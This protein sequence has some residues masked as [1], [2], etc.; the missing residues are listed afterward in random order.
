MDTPPLS[1]CI[2]KSLG[3]SLRDKKTRH[4]YELLEYKTRQKLF[5]SNIIR[6]FI[7]QNILCGKNGKVWSLL[8]SKMIYGGVVQCEGGSGCVKVFLLCL[9]YSL[10]FTR[11]V[12]LE[13][14]KCNRTD[15]FYSEL[16]GLGN[17]FKLSTLT[18]S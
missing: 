14:L 12:C 2:H 1:G 13:S 17:F 18:V 10:F 16:C 11:I 15:L 5:V 4:T 7:S 3:Y 6:T 8:I 9:F